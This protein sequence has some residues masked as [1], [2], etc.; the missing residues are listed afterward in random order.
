MENTIK[1]PNFEKQGNILK[2]TI[3][4][5]IILLLFSAWVSAQIND[6]GVDGNP[7]CQCSGWDTVLDTTETF[8]T[9]TSIAHHDTDYHYH[10][11]SSTN[12]CSYYANGSRGE[13]GEYPCAATAQIIWTAGSNYGGDLGAVYYGYSPTY[14]QHLIGLNQIGQSVNGP[15]A[16]ALGAAAISANDCQT[17]N[18]P[19]CGY[20]AIGFGGA[21]GVT[22]IY[23][24]NEG[25]FGSIL[26]EQA[27]SAEQCCPYEEAPYGSPIVIDFSGRNF[28]GAFTS[29]TDGIRFPF[30]GDRLLQMS[31]TAK[32]PQVGFLVLNRDEATA[33]Q[34][35]VDGRLVAKWRQEPQAVQPFRVASAREMFGNIT[36]Q[37]V[38]KSQ[39]AAAEAMAQ[40][41][42][43]WPTNG[44]IA[45]AEFDLPEFGGNGDDFLDSGDAVWP[46]LMVWIDTAHDGDSTRG[47][48]K[49]LDEMGIKAISLNYTES[50]RC[51]SNGNCIKYTGS[52]VLKDP[53]HL[54]FSIGD[55]YFRFAPGGK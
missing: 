21:N 9:C 51:D 14:N 45:L 24:P 29:I 20:V 1:I 55:V 6:C 40:Q 36:N 22:P 27:F 13:D 44:F 30:F 8:P 43:P 31:W 54:P 41:H 52:V 47:T 16:T 17:G 5:L 12:Y 7:P 37:P 49:T 15:S 33:G 11:A 10:S 32:G 48:M 2:T 18:D 26:L 46:H 42:K 25:E 53:T 35:L 38:Q 23:N 3:A 39:R 4:L 28:D 19:G 34:P 50:N